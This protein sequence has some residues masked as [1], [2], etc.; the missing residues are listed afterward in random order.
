MNVPGSCD[1]CE[2]YQEVRRTSVALSLPRQPPLSRPH[3]RNSI[4]WCLIII[5]TSTHQ[6]ISLH[7]Q[8]VFIDYMKPNN[9]FWG[10]CQ[11][12]QGIIHLLLNCRIFE[13]IVCICSSRMKKKKK[14]ILRYFAANL[15]LCLEIQ[16]QCTF[17]SLQRCHA[18]E[19]F[20]AGEL[21]SKVLAWSDALQMEQMKILRRWNV[22][23]WWFFLSLMDFLLTWRRRAALTG[24]PITGTYRLKQFHFHWG[25]SDE[26]GSEHTV[27]GIQFPCE[28]LTAQP[29]LASHTHTHTLAV[30]CR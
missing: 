20:L 16:Q 3:Q 14:Q 25:A 28:V 7:Y 15:G 30:N 12:K 9:E 17:P 27:N 23:Q 2:R 21:R 26:R 11:S 19:Q 29:A 22:S 5:N 1:K 4:Q 13:T 6:Y 18:C 10:S 24:G 8:S